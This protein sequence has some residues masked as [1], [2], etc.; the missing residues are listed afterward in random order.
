[1]VSGLGGNSD[2]DYLGCLDDLSGL[3]DLGGWLIWVILVVW[4]VC[5]I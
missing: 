1:M 2:L 4:L 5:G 3:C